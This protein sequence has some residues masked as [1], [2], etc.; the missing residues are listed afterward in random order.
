MQ[1]SFHPMQSLLPGSVLGNIGTVFLDTLPLTNI[2]PNPHNDANRNNVDRQN[3]ITLVL[4]LESLTNVQQGP[5]SPLKS[6]DHE[7]PSGIFPW[8]S[9]NICQGLYFRHIFVFLCILIWAFILFPNN[10]E[11]RV[12]TWT[13]QEPTYQARCEKHWAVG[14]SLSLVLSP[15][16]ENLKKTTY[17]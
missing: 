13:H 4:M 5:E 6:R 12:P 10:Q 2:S 11:L 7:S 16:L 15:L 3:V 1:R 9:L 17:Q 14:P 8:S